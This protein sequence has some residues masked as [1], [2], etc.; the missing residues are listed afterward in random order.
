MGTCVCVCVCVRRCLCLYVH[1]VCMHASV[2]NC[3]SVHNVFVFGCMF[4]RMYIA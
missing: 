4:E 3:V 1:A 2:N